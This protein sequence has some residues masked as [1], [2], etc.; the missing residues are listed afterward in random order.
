MK[1][2]GRGAAA[3]GFLVAWVWKLGLPQLPPVAAA[4]APGPPWG[5][6]EGGSWSQVLSQL[7]VRQ[8]RGGPAP[9]RLC[10]LI[11]V[12]AHAFEPEIE[13]ANVYQQKKQCVLRVLAL[14]SFLKRAVF[15]GAGAGAGQVR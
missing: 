9:S 7:R 15:P 13:Y 8:A 4:G 14:V 12:Y 11:L 6:G 3:G 1:S 5:C 2:E 10:S